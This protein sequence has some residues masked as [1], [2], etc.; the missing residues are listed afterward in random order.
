MLP[1]VCLL[2][3]S[4]YLN[5]T[6]YAFAYTSGMRQELNFQGNDFVR[7]LI[8]SQPDAPDFDELGLLGY[9]LRRAN[10]AR[11]LRAA[12][13]VALVLLGTLRQLQH[14]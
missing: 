1:I 14:G 10:P 5:R 8:A 9:L 4:N 6:N 2:Y 7:T 11:L 3:W 12:R 13:A